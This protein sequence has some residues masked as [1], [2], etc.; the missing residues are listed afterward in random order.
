MSRYGNLSPASPCGRCRGDDAVPVEH[1]GSSDEEVHRLLAGMAAPVRFRTS[2]PVE[3]LKP[4]GRPPAGGGRPAGPPPKLPHYEASPRKRSRHA[5]HAHV[6]RPYLDFEKMQQVR[7]VWV[8]MCLL[9][10]I[11]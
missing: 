8:F 1:S 10:E 4:G 2:P 9:C 11:F 3:A 6:Q 7:V 5:K